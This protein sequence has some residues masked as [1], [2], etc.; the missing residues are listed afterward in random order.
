MGD[1]RHFYRIDGPDRFMELQRMGSRWFI[2]E[3]HAKVYPERVRIHAMLDGDGGRFVPLERE[4]WE[5][6][7]GEARSRIGG[8]TDPM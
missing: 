2:H 8:S 6:F 1:G 4:E 3:V 5:R 7:Y